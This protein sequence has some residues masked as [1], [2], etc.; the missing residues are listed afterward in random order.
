MEQL[1]EIQT[2]INLEAIRKL[3]TEKKRAIIDVIEGT[4]EDEF[5]YS[6]DN[7]EDYEEETEE[8]LRILDER[9][10]EYETNPS[11]VITLEELKKEF[12]SDNRG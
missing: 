7:A 3:P 2:L 8:E 11:N 5:D 12:L 4:I 6:D 10:A 9:L 1:E